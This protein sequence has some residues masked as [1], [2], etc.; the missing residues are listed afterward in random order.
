[1]VKDGWKH[2]SALWLK[3]CLTDH[4]Y[5]MRKNIFYPDVSDLFQDDPCYIRRTRGLIESVDVGNEVNHMLW[6]SQLAVLNPPVQFQRLT[7]SMPR[8]TEAVLVNQHNHRIVLGVSSGIT[9][10]LA[11]QLGFWTSVHLLNGFSWEKIGSASW[12]LRFQFSRCKN[13]LA[14]Y[15]KSKSSSPVSQSENLTEAPHHYYHLHQMRHK[16]AKA[17]L[18]WRAWCPIRSSSVPFACVLNNRRSTQ[19]TAINLEHL[20]CSLHHKTWPHRHL[21]P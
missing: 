11:A 6:P 20:I 10:R 18:W 21:I 3:V 1:M 5:P 7:E 19:E 15:W 14:I 2:K 16:G 12:N 8:C 4:L 17:K 13:H 9:F